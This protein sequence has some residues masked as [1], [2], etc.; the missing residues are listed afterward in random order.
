MYSR[1]F[2]ISLQTVR[3]HLLFL[4]LF[5]GGIYTYS[6]GAMKWRGITEPYQMATITSI[7]AGRITRI[8]KQEGQLVK[9]GQIILEQDHRELSLRAKRTKHIYEN[10]SS[11]K[12]AKLKVATLKKDYEATK[13]LYDSSQS[14]SQEELWKKELE[15]SLSVAEVENLTAQ[16]EREKLEWEIAAAQVSN[17]IVKAPFT[18]I[19]SELSIRKG[20]SCKQLEP[21]V[22]VVNISKCRF[23]TYIDAA[24]SA[25]MKTGQQ[26]QLSLDGS[27]GSVV[28][29]GKIEFISPTT[30]ASSGLRRVKVLFDNKDNSIQ[31]GVSGYMFLIPG[32]Q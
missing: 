23:I 19:I 28:R 10:K 30:D 13:Y 6:Q 22:R 17:C 20:E 25:K 15:Y 7:N 12:A 9:K 11:L 3:L 2:F 21:L 16:E 1:H 5:S 31:P 29:K 18:G 27:S 4:L 32:V 24:A 8:N 14:V 26:V